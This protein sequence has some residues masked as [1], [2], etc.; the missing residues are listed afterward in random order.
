M[1]PRS[2][3]RVSQ[4]KEVRGLPFWEFVKSATFYHMLPQEFKKIHV[5]GPFLTSHVFKFPWKEIEERT[6]ASTTTVASA[7]TF[8]STRQTPC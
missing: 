5:S 8:G 2:V 6:V 4:H 1:T 3:V 7:N